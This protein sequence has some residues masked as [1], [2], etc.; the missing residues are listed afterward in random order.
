MCMCMYTYIYIHTYVCVHLANHL[1][2]LA[3]LAEGDAQ[4]PD[5][6]NNKEIHIYIYSAYI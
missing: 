5:D 2:P 6:N 4:V 1:V 3:V